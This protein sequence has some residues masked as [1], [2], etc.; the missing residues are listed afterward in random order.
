MWRR[1]SQSSSRSTLLV[2]LT[3]IAVVALSGC[4]RVRRAN[5]DDHTQHLLV[6][7]SG[8]HV[9]VDHPIVGDATLKRAVELVQREAKRHRADSIR[10]V[11]SD[12]N[13]N[14]WRFFPFSLLVQ[15]VTTSVSAELVWSPKEKAPVSVP[16][17]PEATPTD[18]GVGRVPANARVTDSREG[19]R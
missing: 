14:F 9:A 12:V 7:V 15:P 5:V 6:T 4:A 10:V 8:L 2:V 3:A 13:T 16:E 18:A 17:Q 1:L 19:D 11:H